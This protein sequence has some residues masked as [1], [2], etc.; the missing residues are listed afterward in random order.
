MDEQETQAQAAHDEDIIQEYHDSQYELVGARRRALIAHGAV[1]KDGDQKLRDAEIEEAIPV[2]VRDRA[3]TA[4]I[5]YDLMAREREI[6]WIAAHEPVDWRKE[7]V[8]DSQ[9][10]QGEREP[11]GAQA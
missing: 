1:D 2:E 10:Q 9:P 11:Q 5:S 8:G 3:H 4:A 7:L 6:R